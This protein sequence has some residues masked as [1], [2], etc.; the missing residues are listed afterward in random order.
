MDAKNEVRVGVRE[1]RG[2]LSLYLRLAA[3]GTTVLVT[4]RDD[5]VA[6]IK[7]PASVQR[8]PRRRGGLKG[9]IWMADDFDTLPDD[10]L[11]AM[12][13]SKF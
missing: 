12:K 6:E 7:A 10:V 4:S 1:L 3:E 13:A 9:R 2:K 11:E 8:P 5:V